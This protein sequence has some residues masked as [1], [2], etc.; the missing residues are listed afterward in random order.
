MNVALLLWGYAATL[1][2]VGAYVLRRAKW[3]DRAPWLAIVAWQAVGVSI[4]LAVAFGGLALVMS[5]VPVSSGV[6]GLLEACAMA[7]RDQYATPGGAVTASV[8]LVLAIVVLTRWMF[9]LLAELTRSRQARRRHHDILTV[10]GRVGP[11]SG[12]TL[13]EHDMP[14]VYCLAGRP[15]RIVMTSAASEALQ[16]EQLDAVLAHERAHL[17]GRH[18]VAVAVAVA[19]A[20]AFPWLPAFANARDEVRRL[21]ELLADD[22]ATKSADRLTLAEAMLALAGS[23]PPSGALAARGTTGAARVRR[24]IDGHRPLRAWASALGLATALLL[25]AAPL[26]TLG[27]PAATAGPDCCGDATYQPTL[28]IEHCYATNRETACLAEH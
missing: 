1:A 2:T 12:V 25:V 17:R 8:G 5:T 13:L 6:A 7:I 11:V 26:F 22:H 3:A 28:A 21:V 24:L 19:M 16:G 23:T 9:Y 27:T 20:R 18:D 15:H 4:V 10:I 14:V